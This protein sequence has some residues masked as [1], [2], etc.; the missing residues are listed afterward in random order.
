MMA[1]DPE[2]GSDIDK[3]FDELV[4]EYGKKTSFSETEI[5]NNNNNNN[6]SS[7]NSNSNNSNAVRQ[8]QW[9]HCNTSFSKLDDLVQHLNNVHLTTISANSCKWENCSR[10]GVNQPSRFALVSHLRTHTGEKPFYCVLP[11]CSKHFTR[12]DALLK[13]IKTVHE[14]SNSN[15]LEEVEYPYWYHTKFNNTDKELILQNVEKS[16]KYYSNTFFNPKT[17]EQ[18]LAKILDGE[19]TNTNLNE[20]KKMHLTGLNEISRQSIS[21]FDVNQIDSI[22]DL[23]KFYNNLQDYH[24]L[25]KSLENVLDNELSKD[26]AEKK[27]YFLRCQLLIDALISQ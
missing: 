23:Q 6:N 3:F 7:N 14:V 2:G 21:Q 19:V 26:L 25:L 4:L 8:C 5:D 24:G 11:E 27:K 1:C 16:L 17:N 13:H 22:T 15:N 20:V 9:D 12:S 10:F 18:Q